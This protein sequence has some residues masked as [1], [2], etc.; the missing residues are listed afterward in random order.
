MKSPVT[1][2]SR[3]S[4][5]LLNL[6][7]LC[8]YSLKSTHTLIFLPP[9]ILKLTLVLVAVLGNICNFDCKFLQIPLYFGYIWW[10]NTLYKCQSFYVSM[11]LFTLS[12][13]KEERWIGDR[14]WNV[15]LYFLTDYRGL[16]KLKFKIHLSLTWINHFVLW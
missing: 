2:T 10:K 9:K 6:Y 3:E 13:S 12:F 16:L 1:L 7:Y 11:L 14:G 4:R 8:T 5:I 15:T